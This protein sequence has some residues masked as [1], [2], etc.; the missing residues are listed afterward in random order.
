MIVSTSCS[1]ARPEPKS[2]SGQLAFIFSLNRFSFALGSFTLGF[3]C[4]NFGEYYLAVV[5]DELPLKKLLSKLTRRTGC[6]SGIQCP[7]FGSTTVC[8]F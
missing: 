5:E 8:T 7:V 3:S 6:S 4:Q 1:T 2:V